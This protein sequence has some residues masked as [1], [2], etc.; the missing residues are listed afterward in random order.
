[1]KFINFF[2][3]I[4][5][6]NGIIGGISVFV[7]G[8]LTYE[9]IRNLNLLLACVVCFLI[10]SAGNAM[11][12]FVDVDIDKINKPERVIPSG[13][14]TKKSVFII[15]I[16]LFVVGLV[17]STMLGLQ[18]FIIAL[19]ASLLILLYNLKLKNKGISGN[20]LVAYLGGLPFV[21]GGISIGSYSPALIPFIFAFL[22]HFAREILKDVEDVPGDRTINSISF[23]IK[24]GNRRAILFS[25]VL[26]IVLIGVSVLPFLF[27]LYGIFYLIGVL[28]CIDF[29]L[30]MVIYNLLKTEAYVLKAS[31]L[32]KFNM[33]IGLGV[34]ALGY[35]K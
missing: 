3:L 5:P 29:P 34:L 8:L 22:L 25:C 24:Y 26:L 4:R 15:S 16:I 1:M 33:I 14:Y 28:I 18:M 9:N 31:N 23:P 6:L 19:L 20:L 12:D 11:N 17:I 21:Y 13:I 2:K 7:G 30:L 10:I 35:Y 32:L 27:H